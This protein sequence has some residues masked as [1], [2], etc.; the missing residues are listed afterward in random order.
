MRARRARW[1][2]FRKTFR[3]DPAR[4]YFFTERSF[5]QQQKFIHGRRGPYNVIYYHKCIRRL[6]RV[7]MAGRERRGERPPQPIT[8]RQTLS[9]SRSALAITIILRLYYFS[10][11]FFS[12]RIHIRARALTLTHKG[13]KRFL[14]FPSFS[15]PYID[16]NKPSN[17]TGVADA[18]PTKHFIGAHR[19]SRSVLLLFSVFFFFFFFK[20]YIVL[21]MQPT[22][23]NISP[24]S[25]VL[26]AFHT[27]LYDTIHY[28]KK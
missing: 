11:F 13:S 23:I 19:V 4:H 22:N 8:A 20:H 24:K 15:H 7:T 27:T 2:V 1:D 16:A 17:S 9:S 10:S 12:L 21:Y 28:Q 3:R 26:R 18:R 14:I 5:E 25:R 6:R